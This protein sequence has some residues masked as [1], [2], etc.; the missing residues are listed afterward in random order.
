[1]TRRSTDFVP[2]SFQYLRTYSRNCFGTRP[3]IQA[4]LIPE[5]K[6]PRSQKLPNNK[7]PKF[8]CIILVSHPPPNSLSP[9]TL[10]SQGRQKRSGPSDFAPEPQ[11]GQSQPPPPHS[12]RW[13]R[14]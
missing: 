8:P 4:T 13:T 5:R 7:T 10:F 12:P 2:L 3:A 11:P 9:P 14:R 1:M 6:G